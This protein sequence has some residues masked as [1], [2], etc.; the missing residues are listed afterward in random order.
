MK[1][2]I[3]MSEQVYF[4]GLRQGARVSLIVVGS[5]PVVWENHLKQRVAHEVLLRRVN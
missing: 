2:A 3:Q 5:K 4:R 1:R